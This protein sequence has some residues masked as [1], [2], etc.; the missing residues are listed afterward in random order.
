MAL[1]FETAE[2]QA[3]LEAP[4]LKERCEA[5]VALMVIGAAGG[6]EESGPSIQ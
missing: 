1:P 5:L 2:K 6:D 4:T 3:L